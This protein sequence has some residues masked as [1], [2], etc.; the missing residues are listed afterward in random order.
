M[1]IGNR[2]CI[3]PLVRLPVDV[4]GDHPAHRLQVTILQKAAN[5]DEPVP[6]VFLDPVA[7]KLLHLSPPGHGSTLGA[8]PGDGKPRVR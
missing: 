6:F 4:G 5:D 1:Q 7:G 2:S 3:T 8:E